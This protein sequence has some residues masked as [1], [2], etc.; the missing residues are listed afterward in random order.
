MS[1]PEFDEKSSWQAAIIEPLSDQLSQEGRIIHAMEKLHIIGFPNEIVFSPIGR[2]GDHL[3]QTRSRLE[4]KSDLTRARQEPVLV[5]SVEDTLRYRECWLMRRR[6]AAEP[7]GD[8]RD[9]ARHVLSVLEDHPAHAR[10]T[11]GDHAGAGWER[12][13]SILAQLSA[14]RQK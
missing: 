2:P 6:L 9:E 5:F 8:E 12:Y 14:V 13:W 4:A 3:M 11:H 7:D 10:H 1:M